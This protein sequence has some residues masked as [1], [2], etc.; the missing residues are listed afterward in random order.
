MSAKRLNRN[1]YA[2]LPN[3]I[4]GWLLG[5]VVGLY[6]AVVVGLVTWYG[7]S[8]NQ[9]LPDPTGP[10]H[11]ETIGFGAGTGLKFHPIFPLGSKALPATHAVR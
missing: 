1:P 6:L 8:P 4:L 7:L 5:G 3:G 2:D 10:I 9:N 11:A